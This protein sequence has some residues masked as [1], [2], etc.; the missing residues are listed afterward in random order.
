MENLKR[1]WNVRGCQ[2]ED[3]LCNH[4]TYLH[5]PR[6]C[7]YD[8]E[9]RAAFKDWLGLVWSSI[10]RGLRSSSVSTTTNW[11][12]DHTRVPA[13]PWNEG[14]PGPFPSVCQRLDRNF[15]RTCVWLASVGSCYTC[16]YPNCT[17]LFRKGTLAKEAIASGGDN[18]TTRARSPLDQ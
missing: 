18:N 1:W 6:L 9:S 13:E 7:W 2:R 4:S 14:V 5:L 3:F 17:R 15:L 10:Q 16:P 12:Q 11:P 8:K